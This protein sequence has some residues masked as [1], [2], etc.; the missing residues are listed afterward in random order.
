MEGDCVQARYSDRGTWQQLTIE[1]DGLGCIRAGDAVFLKTHT[2]K[3]IDVHSNS[4][5][6]RWQDRG[7]WQKLIIQKVR[8]LS[9]SD[10]T[11]IRGQ[12]LRESTFQGSDSLAAS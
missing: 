12:D 3:H 7:D 1:K 4:V 5:Q 10:L 6:A 11:R 2:G 9:L 8:V